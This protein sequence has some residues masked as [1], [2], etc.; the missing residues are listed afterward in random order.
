MSAT[1]KIIL[2]S[3]LLLIFFFL[4]FFFLILP[5]VKKINEISK[6]IFQTKIKLGEIEKRQEEIEKFK[7]LF[8]ATKE[9]LSKFENSLVNKEIPIDFVEFLERIA[10][11]LKL[12]I[13][14]SI[15]GSTKDTLSFQIR[16]VGFPENVFRFIEKVENCNFLIQVERIRFSKLTEAELNMKEFGGFSQ[17]DLKFE[18]SISVLTR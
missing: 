13:Q 9:N 2:F 14:I 1:K 5:N 6:E 16:G 3:I 11:D 4:F 17:N 7:R 12:S 8:P 15:L 18:I 10:A